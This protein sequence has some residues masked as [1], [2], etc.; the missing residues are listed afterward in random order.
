MSEKPSGNGPVIVV[1]IDGSPS[2]KAAL[3]WAVG[4]ARL[5]GSAIHAVIAW[6][7]PAFYPAEPII[8]ADD[9]AEAAGTVL[10]ETVAEVLGA[11]PSVEVR[12]SVE[13]GNPAQVLLNAARTA[14]LLVVGS[15]G[16]GGFTSALLGSVGHYCAAHA[17]CPVVIIR[18]GGR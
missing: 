4:Q 18:A 16:H 15:R 2:S 7:F 1:G 5:T 13:L 14:E 3:G 12:E 8:P 10:S 11:G 17:T 9:L 6:E